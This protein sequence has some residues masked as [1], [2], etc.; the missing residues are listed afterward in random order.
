MRRARSDIQRTRSTS[1]RSLPDRG[2]R[3]FS[4]N[5][6]FQAF[7]NAEELLSAG[8]LADVMIVATQDNSHFEHC[9]GALRQNYDVLL[10]K[11]IATC[12]EQVLEIQRLAQDP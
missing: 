11:P 5:F 2:R 6:E 9:K 4:G 8:K 1:A 7:N 12:V 10:E 3:R